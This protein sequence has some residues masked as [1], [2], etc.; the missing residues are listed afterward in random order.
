METLSLTSWKLAC[1]VEDTI[2]NG[3]ICLKLA[4]QQVALFYLTRRN[5]WYATQNEC[6]QKQQIIITSGTIGSLGDQA[7]LACPFHKKTFA[8]DTGECLSGDECAIKTYPVKVEN[9]CVYIA[10]QN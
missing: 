5:E 9:G 6:P 10:L 3:G 8:L 4:D 2:E 7:K 1:R